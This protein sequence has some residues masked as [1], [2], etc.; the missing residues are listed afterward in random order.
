MLQQ[1]K[2]SDVLVLDP[3]GSNLGQM[4]FH[5]AQLLAT[6]RYS[7]DLVQINKNENLPVYKIMDFGKWKFAQSKQKKNKISTGKIKEVHFKVN[8]DIHDLNT[9]INH[10]KEFLSK[11]NEVKIAVFMKGRE[12]SHPQLARQK[13]DAILSDLGDLIQ[14]PPKI[15]EETSSV[16]TIVKRK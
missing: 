11:G 9:K 13:M 7:L 12:K 15:K 2:N 4:K 16:N 10:I 5:D 3:S 6:E 1:N 8:T 14:S